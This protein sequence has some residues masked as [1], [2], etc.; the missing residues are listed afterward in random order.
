M[1]RE[2]IIPDDMQ[3]IVSRAGYAPAVMAGNI[4]Y[5][6]GQVGRSPALEVIADPADQF[7]AMW[8]NL[9]AVLA[10]AGCDFDDIVEMTSYHVDMARHM[11]IFRSIKNAVFPRGTCAWTCV[12]VA[13]LAHPGLLAEVKCIAVRR[14]ALPA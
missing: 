6:A 8:Q 1:Q 9:Q 4:L 10:A 13:E 7:R 2:I 11:P 12:G 14:Q 3:E 5:C